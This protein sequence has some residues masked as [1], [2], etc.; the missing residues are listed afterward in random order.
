M[1]FETVQLALTIRIASCFYT[2]TSFS[3][4]SYFATRSSQ[5]NILVKA[6]SFFLKSSIDETYRHCKT[7]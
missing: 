1:H 5:Q 3:S 7:S 6:D 4:S 2:F